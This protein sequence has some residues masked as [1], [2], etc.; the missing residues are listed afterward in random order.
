MYL[1]AEGCFSEI[2]IYEQR[3]SF[4]GVWNYTPDKSGG[5]VEIPQTN[6]H[7]ALEEPL[8]QD[9]ASEDGESRRS[10]K[11]ARFLSPMYDRLETNIA[12]KMMAYSDDPAIAKNQLFPDRESVLQYLEG[13]ADDVKHLVKFETQVTTVRRSQSQ[14]GKDVWH[15]ESRD[16]DLD[17]VSSDTYDAIV[18]ASGHY[19]VPRIPDIKNIKQWNEAYPGRISHSKF[20]R[21]PEEFASLKTVIVGQSAS[22]LDISAQISPYCIPPLIVSQRSLPALPNGHAS[23]SK[24]VKPEIIEFLPPSSGTCERAV[25]FADGHVGKDIDAVLFCTGY[26]Y[27]YPFLSSL[28]PPLIT[29]GDRVHHL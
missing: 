3:A 6:P 17:R 26:H 10:R 20:Y 1:L 25:R 24:R 14:S 29:N 7:Q 12:H 18:V 15:L 4:G 28:Q 27:A 9:V 11:Q 2:A 13:Y 16:L 23:T 21:R 22:G 19:S 5:K 8:W